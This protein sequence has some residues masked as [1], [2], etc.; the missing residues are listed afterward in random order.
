MLF[1][2]RLFEFSINVRQSL[3]YEVFDKISLSFQGMCTGNFL[4]AI[5]RRE[6]TFYVV[7]FSGDHLLVPA[8]NHSQVRTSISTLPAA[9]VALVRG[10]G[11][12]PRFNL[13]NKRKQTECLFSLISLCLSNSSIILFFRCKS[14]KRSRNI[15]YTVCTKLPG[16]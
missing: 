2:A 16:V 12:N 7:S 15:L 9:E 5:E 8:T 10:P 11:L 1:L 6:D 4:Q 14:A 3:W 13:Q